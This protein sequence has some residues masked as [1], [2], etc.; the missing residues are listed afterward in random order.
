M[1]YPYLPYAWTQKG[2]PIRQYALICSMLD[3]INPDK[4]VLVYVWFLKNI[5]KRKKMLKENGFFI[6]GFTIRK[7]KTNVINIG[8]YIRTFFFSWKICSFLMDTTCF[9]GCVLYLKD[10]TSSKGC[11]WC[12]KAQPFKGCV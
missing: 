4:N 9:K 1:K 8:I 12:L 11:V 5:K 6:F 3:F 2:P 7:K 10:I